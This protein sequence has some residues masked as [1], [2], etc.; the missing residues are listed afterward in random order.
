MPVYEYQCKDCD[1]VI[2]VM[3]RIGD[4]SSRICVKCGKKMT[5]LISSNNF[6]LKG[7]GWYKDG[8]SKK[9]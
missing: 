8:Y 2:E 1:R 5:K 9:A 4:E 6:I 3:K 7:K